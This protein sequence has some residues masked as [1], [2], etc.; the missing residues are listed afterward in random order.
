MQDKNLEWDLEQC[1]NSAFYHMET[2]VDLLKRATSMGNLNSESI[3]QALE[4]FEI[5]L[6][7]MQ[8]AVKPHPKGAT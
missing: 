1:F 5:A 3:K 6:S 7:N 2:G 8:E 4:F